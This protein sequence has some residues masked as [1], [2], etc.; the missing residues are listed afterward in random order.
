MSDI[1]LTYNGATIATM[2]ASGTK[3]LG[4]A[5]KYCTD[6]ITLTYV[7]SGGGIT[8]APSK[9]VNF[10]DYDG[11]ILYSYTA[12]EFAAL[13]ALPQ[14][15]THDGLTAQGWNWTLADAKAQVL[16]SGILDIGQMYV[17]SD[18]KSR[19]YITISDS[20]RMSPRVQW[21]QTVANGVTID[22]G[23]GSATETSSGT[24][25][26]SRKHTYSSVGEYVITLSVT[27]GTATLGWSSTSG[28]VV[29]GAKAANLYRRRIDKIEV[30]ARI[31]GIG[32][33]Y[34][35]YGIKTITI[36]KTVTTGY[37]Y[38]CTSLVA[39][40]VPDVVT[41]FF[42]VR[43]CYA[44]Q[45]VSIPKSCTTY[46]PYAFAYSYALRRI[47]LPSLGAVPAAMF[48][49]NYSLSRMVVPSSVTSIAASSFS[50]CTGLAEIHFK[51]TTPP[52]VADSNAWTNLPTD[53]KIYVPT[54]KLSAYTGAG[55]YPDPNTYTYVE[56]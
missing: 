16:V 13:T 32:Y 45:V 30:G 47:S 3:T 29:Y 17:T 7:K 49:S 2:D 43:M 40:V 19:I 25:N 6:D 26:K 46:N 38:S 53:C 31:T 33:I 54:G 12:A 50:N 55:N 21:N 44:L 4:T 23:D 51:P 8:A 22:W 35:T 24:G 28:T 5:G 56:E 41:T 36:P 37:F 14:N 34:D 20:A 48:P 52:T 9:D 10:I 1:T 27:S 11:T 39:L 42:G 15:P 18:G